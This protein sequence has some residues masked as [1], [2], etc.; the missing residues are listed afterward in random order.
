MLYNKKKSKIK[1]VKNL[2]L[3]F[4]RISHGSL[5]DKRNHDTSN[6]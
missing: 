4:P 6:L 1:H 5:E 3:A 2:K